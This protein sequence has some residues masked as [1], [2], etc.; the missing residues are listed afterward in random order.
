MGILSGHLSLCLNALTGENIGF[1]VI[2]YN[3]FYHIFR[4]GGLLKI[5]MLLEKFSTVLSYYGK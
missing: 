4:L 5:Q 3:F 2:F 1:N